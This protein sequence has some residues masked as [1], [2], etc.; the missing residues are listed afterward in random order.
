MEF[1]TFFFN[2][3]RTCCY[4]A[5]DQTGH[6]IIIDPGCF[7]PTEEQRLAGYIRNN[8]LTPLYIVN[9]HCHFDHLMGLDF[10]RKT[11]NIPLRMHPFELGNLE[12]AA[13]YARLFGFNIIQP[14]S[15]YTALSDGEVLT[16][17]HSELKVIHTPGHSPGSV[18]LYGSRDA[19][20][21]TGDVL[22][23]GSVGRTDLPG[24]DYDQ[25]MES[26]SGKIGVL[27]PETRIYPG[28]GPSSTLAGEFA[29]NPYLQHLV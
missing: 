27:P 2:A 4:L 8:N 12:R 28:H 22:F 19:V 17:G 18:C 5:Y 23:A 21:F 14:R 24:G 26:L 20:L 13:N 7:G 9:T 11:Y 1:K 15:D 3:L 29:V 10:I 25:L 6:C 16:F